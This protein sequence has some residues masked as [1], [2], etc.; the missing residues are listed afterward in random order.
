MDGMRAMLKSAEDAKH[1]QPEPLSLLELR[2]EL[3][4]LATSMQQQ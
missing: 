4:G 3:R 2:E 1:L